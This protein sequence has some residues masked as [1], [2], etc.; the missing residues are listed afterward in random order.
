[1]QNI[2]HPNSLKSKDVKS[3][4]IHIP[5]CRKKCFYCA[6]TSFCALNLIDDYIKNL[7]KEIKYFYE[8]TPLKTLY[9]GGGTPSLLN[10]KQF[11]KI[12]SLFNFEKNPEITVE[13]NP[14]STNLNLLYQLYKLGVNRLSIGVQ[15]FNDD[16]LKSIGRLHN[17]KQ[18]KDIIRL[19]QDTGFNNISIDLIYG[20][21]QKENLKSAPALWQETLNEA[22]N[23]EIE[24]I[25]LYGLKIEENTVFYKKP[26]KN[27]PDDDMQADM[28]EFAINYLSPEY[29]LYE[30]SNLAKSD[31][32]K[33]RHNLNY[34]DEGEYFGFGTGASGYINNIRYKN[35]DN[36]MEYSASPVN[37]KQFTILTDKERLEET[38]FLGLRKREGI[39]TKKIEEKF[40][41]DFNKTYNY[42][43]E[44][45]LN[46]RHLE[47]TDKGI[48]LTT[49]GML[50]SNV[51]MSEFLQ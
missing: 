2:I 11:E 44:K 48:R 4:Y 38:I 15:S 21:P 22:K 39:D 33:S 43:I 45:Y 7:T 37:S 16:I 13:L 10:I 26:P 19:A 34:W 50:L 30:I 12:L 6:F 1:M 9:I 47:K 51:I 42:I 41:I 23:L 3:V 5:F 46:S 36:F 28:Y 31:T 17:S 20:L 49:E 35:T 27:L 14:D 29:S 8:G 18:A 24:H 25:S 40:S 32:F